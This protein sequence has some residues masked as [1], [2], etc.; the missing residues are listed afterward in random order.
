MPEKMSILKMNSRLTLQDLYCSGRPAPEGPTT[1][2][3]VLIIGYGNSLR[4]DDGVGL[5]AAERLLDL[6]LGEQTEVLVRQQLTPE[7]AEPI[8]RANLVI[9]I[10]ASV[11]AAAGTITSRS[12]AAATSP[13]SSLDHDCEAPVLLRYAKEFYGKTPEAVLLTVAGDCFDYGHELSTA[14]SA[15]IPEIM[16]RVEELLLEVEQRR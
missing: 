7:L 12:I 9:F 16:K 2:G 6:N 5:I 3:K 11:G 13:Q 4:G 8:S 15:A 14:V 1:K 10:D